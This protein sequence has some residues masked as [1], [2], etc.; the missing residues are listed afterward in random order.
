MS[1]HREPL[2]HFLL[3]GAALFAVHAWLN[4]GVRSDAPRQ[5]RIGQSDV[6]WLEETWARQWQREPS[7][8][9]LRGLVTEF[10]KEELL[11]R[12][13]REMGLDQNDP[14]LRRRLAQKVEFLVQDASRLAEP[15]EDDLR[16]FHAAHPELFLDEARISFQQVYFRRERRDQAMAALSRLAA[17]ADPKGLGDRLSL[18]EPELRDLPEQAVAAQ[19]GPG[20]AREVLALPPEAWRGPIESGY[21]LHLVRVTGRSPARQ[22]D[23]EA[24]R[25]LV[26]ERWR[27]ERQREANE[28]Y[29]AGLLRK[30][31]VVVDESVKPLVGPLGRA[32]QLGEAVR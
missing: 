28:R 19:L 32:T 15:T 10:L 5:V 18:L 29:F 26:A 25:E 3:L 20:F 11:A 8:D 21:G 30:Y 7:R 16:R 13:A 1:L 27:D 9:E 17:G 24:A 22:R 4:R 6:Q 23:L 14:Y 12:E 31:D 2:L